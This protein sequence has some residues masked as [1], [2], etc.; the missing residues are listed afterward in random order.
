MDLFTQLRLCNYSPHNRRNQ[1]IP[2]SR[3]HHLSHKNIYL[4]SASSYYSLTSQRTICSLG[5]S[6]RWLVCKDLN[7]H[8][9]ASDSYASSDNRWIIFLNWIKDKLKMAIILSSTTR[10][11]LHLQVDRESAL[12]RPQA[13]PVVAN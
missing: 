8:N 3:R 4:L 13:L 12:G 11:S 2:V 9:Q 6:R 1:F 5:A 10:T 7:A